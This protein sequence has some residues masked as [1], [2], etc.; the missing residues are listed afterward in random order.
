MEHTDSAM[1]KRHDV[2]EPP[3]LVASALDGRGPSETLRGTRARHRGKA[4]T[5]KSHA[6]A[7][8]TCR[9]ASRVAA[10]KDVELL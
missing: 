8:A 7:V 3:A 5:V 10:P 2:Q 6:A 9:G 1:S 4:E